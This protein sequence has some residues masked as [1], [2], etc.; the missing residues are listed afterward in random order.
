MK[1]KSTNAAALF[2]AGFFAKDIIDDVFFLMI[3]K[4]PI[5]IFGFTIT[6]TSH[7]TMLVVS[8]LLTLVLL[9]YGL[10]NRTTLNQKARNA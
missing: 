6:A 4:Y 10:R 8:I 7:K 2:L 3:D 9:Y 5:E 1:T